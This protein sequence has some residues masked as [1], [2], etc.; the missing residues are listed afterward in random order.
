MLRVNRSTYY[1]HFSG[2][3]SN[4]SIENQKIRS[5]ILEIYFKYKKRLGAYKIKYFLEVEY[6]I[7]ISVGRVYRLMKSIDLPKMSTKKT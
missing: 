4:R 5:Y 2:N 1:K 7:N 3:I 6:G